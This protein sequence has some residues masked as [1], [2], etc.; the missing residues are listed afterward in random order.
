MRS[1]PSLRLAAVA[2]IS[3]GHRNVSCLSIS[4]HDPSLLHLGTAGNGVFLG[5]DAGV[6]T[7]GGMSSHD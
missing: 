3:P 1:S 4:P 6:R 7:K 2:L 5:K